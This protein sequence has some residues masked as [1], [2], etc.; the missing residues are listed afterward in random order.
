MQAGNSRIAQG[1]VVLLTSLAPARDESSRPFLLVRQDGWRELSQPIGMSVSLHS[2]LG[3]APV[4]VAG[5]S[6]LL[7][8]PAGAVPRNVIGLIN[9]RC[10]QP[11][12]A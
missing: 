7:R 4:R 5:S 8:Q 11:P 2:Q 9:H 12:A 1:L 3:R 10:V 6:R